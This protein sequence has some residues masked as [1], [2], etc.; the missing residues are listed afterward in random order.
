MQSSTQKSWLCH[1]YR[2]CDI[3]NVLY[4]E[5]LVNVLDEALNKTVFHL[6]TRNQTLYKSSLSAHVKQKPEVVAA[7]AVLS[8]NTSTLNVLNVQALLYTVLTSS[9]NYRKIT[10][11]SSSQ[12]LFMSCHMDNAPPFSFYFINTT[13]NLMTS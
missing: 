9:V 2:G 1:A 3:I 8:D 13:I 7:N 4:K 6:C 12:D 5:L 10:R 11:K